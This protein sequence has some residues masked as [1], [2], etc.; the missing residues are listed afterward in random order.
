MNDD[1]TQAYEYTKDLRNAL[2]AEIQAYE[3]GGPRP[4]VYETLRALD[5]IVAEGDNNTVKQFT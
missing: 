4:S 5:L 3:R 2:R 1:I